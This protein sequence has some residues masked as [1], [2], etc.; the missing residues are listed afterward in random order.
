MCEPTNLPP[1]P[2]ASL[3]VDEPR[4]IIVGDKGRILVRGEQ[5]WEAMASPTTEDLLAAAVTPT[6][7]W[8]VGTGGAVLHLQGGEWRQEDLGTT[9]TLRSVFASPS[10][11]AWVVGDGGTVFHHDGT[12]WQR[13][14]SM[15]PVEEDLRAVHGSSSGGVW[16]V[17]GRGVLLHWD[18]LA[19]RHVPVP[20]Q[21]QLGTVFVDG[22]AVYVAGGGV[23]MHRDF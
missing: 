15:P 4:A 22:A 20:S 18:G 2:G 11:G 19:L 5:G 6:D 3:A 13:E 9:A 8:A 23:V 21:A 14:Q 1:V 16:M 12:R 7:A 17:G 10:G